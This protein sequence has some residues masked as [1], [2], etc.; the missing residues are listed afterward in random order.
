MNHMNMAKG[1][2]ATCGTGV[3]VFAAFGARG[4]HSAAVADGL[5]VGSFSVHDAMRSDVSK[6]LVSMTATA[7]RTDRADC[8]AA[9][10]GTSPADADEQQQRDGSPAPTPAPVITA[11]GAA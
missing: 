2:A 11:A 8:E 5:S 4:A 10:C 3:L 1:I 6:P 7:A 9:S